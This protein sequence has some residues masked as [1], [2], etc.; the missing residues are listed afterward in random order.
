MLNLTKAYFG[1]SMNSKAYRVYNKIS[2]TIEE[3]IHVV[4]DEVDSLKPKNI[5]NNDDDIN[6]IE[7][8]ANNI[9]MRYQT[10]QDSNKK[11]SMKIASHLE[12]DQQFPKSS[13]IVKDHPIDQILGDPS[14]GVNTR[15]SL[16]N[17]CNNMAV[18]SEIEPNN[19]EKAE[20]GEC[21]LMAIEEELNQFERNNVWTLVPRPTHQSIIGT[22]W[23]FRNKNDENGIIIRNKARLVAQG[24]NQEK[25]ID[26]EETFA[27]IVRLKAIRMLLAFVC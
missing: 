19:I 12:Q 11:E 5:D 26:Y 13:R 27:P 17:V 16:R 7:N 10:S 25:S 3:S 22:K 23:V 8:K 24:F 21:W 15:S 1:Y 14:Q 18:V 9:N 4:F 20:T 6:V 2:L